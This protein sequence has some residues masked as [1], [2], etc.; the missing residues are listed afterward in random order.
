MK[1]QKNLTGALGATCSEHGLRV[2]Y[3]VIGLNHLLVN[4]GG[5]IQYRV[6]YA[7]QTL[8]YKSSELSHI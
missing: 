6:S 3:V 7:A 5:K 2:K 8:F 4:Y 1:I